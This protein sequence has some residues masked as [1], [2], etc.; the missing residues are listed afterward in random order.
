V[1]NNGKKFAKHLFD[2]F[3]NLVGY[4]TSLAKC[5]AF[6]CFLSEF[7]QKLKFLNNSIFNI[8]LLFP[9]WIS[10]LMRVYGWMILLR[11]TG[12]INQIIHKLG[13]WKEPVEL[14][15]N[16]VSMIMGL[17][18]TSMLFVLCTSIFTLANLCF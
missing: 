7:V 17:V 18:Y 6:C 3:D 5:G 14:L 12:V 4:R 10:E 15:Y 11:E 8:L 1:L 2:L 16:D 9:F 13:I